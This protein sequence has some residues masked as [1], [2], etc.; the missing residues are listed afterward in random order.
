[1]LVAVGLLGM[2][3]LSIGAALYLGIR[4]TRNNYTRLDQSNAEMSI[5]RHLSGD[6][7]AAERIDDGSDTACVKGTTK[8]SSRSPA[9]N[10]TRN[11]IVVW[12]LD[13]ASNDLTRTLCVDGVKSDSFTV[14]TNITAFSV[15]PSSPFIS[16]TASFTA[17]GSGSGANA[18]DSRSWSLTIQRRGVR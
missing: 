14:A 9:T 18:V 5:T 1:M 16:A 6:I 13:A 7:Y 8:I 3:M 2:V 10:A 11:V 15:T 17:G 12:N 4:T